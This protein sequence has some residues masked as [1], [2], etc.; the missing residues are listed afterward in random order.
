MKP[1]SQGFYVLK[2]ESSNFEPSDLGPE[3]TGVNLLK[4]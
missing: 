1:L 2:D 4:A 3:W